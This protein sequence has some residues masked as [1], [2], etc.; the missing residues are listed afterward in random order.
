MELEVEEEGYILSALGH[1]LLHVRLKMK[2]L[3]CLQN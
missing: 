2:L 1:C 3:K